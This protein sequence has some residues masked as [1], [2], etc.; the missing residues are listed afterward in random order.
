MDYELYHYGI[1][2]MKWGV[3]RSQKQLARINKKAKR[4]NWSEEAT[5]AARVR[6]KSVK[7]MSNA[8]LRKLNERTRLENEY[9][10]LKKGKPSAGRKFVSEVSREL[11]KEAVKTNV[12]KGSKW[13]AKKLLTGI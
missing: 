4:Q 9:A 6:T 1:P 3:R 5:D 11:A 2:G 8:E 10:T 7:R 13:V 12:K